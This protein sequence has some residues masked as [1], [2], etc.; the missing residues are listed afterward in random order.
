RSVISLRK[1]GADVKHSA[2][3]NTSEQHFEKQDAHVSP[4]ELIFQANM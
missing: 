1:K 4:G 2:A 3:F